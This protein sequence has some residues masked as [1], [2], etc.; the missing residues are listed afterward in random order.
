MQKQQ[1]QG[2]FAAS[3]LFAVRYMF[4]NILDGTVKYIAQGIEYHGLDDPV[5]SQPLK[6]GFVDPVILYQ[7]ILADIFL[8]HRPPQWIVAYQFRHLACL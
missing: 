1:R 3:L 7:L 4:D 2:I 5:V 6:L 8:F